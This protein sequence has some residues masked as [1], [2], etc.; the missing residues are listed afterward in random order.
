LWDKERVGDGATIYELINRAEFFFGIDSGPGHIA[1]ASKTPA[2]LFWWG[3]H[4]AHCI[5]PSPNV[6]H[7]IPDWSDE[8]F[9]LPKRATDYFAKHYQSHVYG[10]DLTAYLEC[11][12]ETLREPLNNE[13]QTMENP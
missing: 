7:C 11:V 4:P 9:E 10:P 8:F 12:G 13:S 1:A 3:H 5:I 2:F 6:T